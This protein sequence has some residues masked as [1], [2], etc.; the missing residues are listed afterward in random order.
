MSSQ[1]KR[2]KALNEQNLKQIACTLDEAA[3]GVKACATAK[4][5]ETVELAFT[6]GVD[7]RH[8]DQMVRGTVSLPHGTGKQVRVVVFCKETEQINAAR[9]AGAIDAGAEE[10]LQKV[11]GGWTDFDVAVSTPDMMRD[12]G[13][14]GKVLGPR[15]LMPSPKAGTVTAKVGEAVTEILK[16][17]IDFRV[18]KNANIHV[19][20][21][22]ASFAVEQIRENAAAVV[23]A[24]VKARPAACKGTYLKSCCMSSTMGPGFRLDAPSLVSQFRA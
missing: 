10:L 2:R 20:I 17:K 13:K 5:D 1:S 23:E 11:Q 4:F 14:L 9:E 16:G 21:G 15:G 8:A 3:T 22:K 6:L 7:P 24:V 18:D 12:V 19:P